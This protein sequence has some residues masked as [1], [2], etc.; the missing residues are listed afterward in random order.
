M[1]EYFDKLFGN[2]NIK[3][4]LGDAI[5]KSRLPHAL[6][7]DGPDGSG[8]LTLAKEIAAAVNCQSRTNDHYPLPCGECE[9]CRKIASDGHTD[10]RIL[11]RQDGKATIGVGEVAQLKSDT[12]LSATEADYKVYIIDGAERMTVEAQNSLLILLEEPPKNVIMMLLSVSSDKILTTIK[13]RTQYLPMQ[14]FGPEELDKLLSKISEQY[15]R[16]KLQSPEECA[17]ITVLSDGRLGRAMELVKAGGIH[18][19]GDGYEKV[20][21]IAEAIAKRGSYLEL[22]SAISALSSKRQDLIEELEL[23]MNAVR[24]MTLSKTAESFTPL[25]FA[26]ASAAQ[27]TSASLSL[28]KLGRV[29]DALSETHE[30]IFKN[31]NIAAASTVLTAKIK[32]II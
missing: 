7:I 26:S 27:E 31:A 15:R 29:F 17:K 14:R 21:R 18:G 20:M 11:S 24:D 2:E 32:N 16:M 5:V 23:L 19:A 13:S 12:Y 30:A 4:R 6:L 10:V 1:R 9:S 3:K 8:K 25:F 28:A 22:N